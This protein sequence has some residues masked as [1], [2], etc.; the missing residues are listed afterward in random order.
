MSTSHVCRF[1]LR[2]KPLT[3]AG[4]CDQCTN[5]LFANDGKASIQGV[6]KL[7]KL[8]TATLRRLESTGQLTVDRNEAGSRR[9]SKATIESYILKSSDQLAARLTKGK[10]QEVTMDEVEQLS[11]PFSSL[12][13][14]CN[15]NDVFDK[16]Y[17]IDCLSDLISKV[18]ATKIL[19]ISLPR[20]ERLLEEYP[21]L[22]HTYPYMT[23]V[24]MSKR[25]VES[26]LANQPAK[27]VSRGARWSNHFR[28]CRICKTTDNEHYGGGY[29]IECYPKTNEAKLLKGYLGGENL[30]E[31]GVRLGFS[32]ERARQL[33][34]KAV[35]IDIERLGDVTEYRK[36]EIRDQIE[37]TYKQN[38]AAREFKHIIEENYQE[39]V[40]KLS[41]EI[42][43][44]ESGIVKAIGLPPSASY[45]IDEEYPEFLEI[46]ANNKNRWSWKYD[47][48]RMC[49][50]TEAKHKRWGYCENCYT[51]SDE[52]KKQQYEYRTNNYEKFREHQKAYE[53]EY[54]KRPEVKERM[55]QK[56]Y[57]RRYDG[58]RE[59]T[60]EADNYKCRDCGINRDDHKAKYGQDLGVFHIDGNLDNNNPSNLVTLCKSCMA[61]RGTSAADE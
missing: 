16:G 12:C 14:L 19:G 21:D 32:R 34:N 29:C 42:I 15:D 33:F 24:R 40:N 56:S 43:I 55:I 49:G 2:H 46:I 41:S 44:S 9:Y 23:Q 48:C 39:I 54:H 4:V 37:L 18:D 10:V 35:A 61:R 59:A 13:P 38:R 52:W 26:F 22:I 8:S 51:R 53:A 27:E 60:I 11:A 7:L 36:Q 25:E 31:I 58:K 6:S 47:V 1:C 20:L 57:K 50:K 3:V 5:D 17:C 28:Q 30:S 45:L